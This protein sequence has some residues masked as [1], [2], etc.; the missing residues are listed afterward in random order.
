MKKLLSIF[1]LTIVALSVHSFTWPPKKTKVKVA[2]VR[3]LTV[4]TGT[5]IGDIAPDIKQN[6]PDGKELSLYSLRGKIVLIDFWA[7][8]C[9]PCRQSNPKVVALYKKY[10]KAK[11]KTAKGFEVFSVSLDKSATSWKAAIEKDG[12]IWKYHVSDLMHWANKAVATY[13][14][15]GIPTTFLIDENGK[16]IGKNLKEEELHQ[17][18]DNLIEK[19]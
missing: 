18:L 12:L 10:S 15:I 19:L 16:I 3:V 9:A 11:F 8:W 17:K 7:S 13:N 1:I 14:I 4:Q 6:N 5:N 2:K